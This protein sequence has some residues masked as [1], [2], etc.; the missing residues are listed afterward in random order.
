MV[1][2][3]GKCPFGCFI[4][5]VCMSILLYA[6]DILLIAPSVTSLQKLLHIFDHEISCIDMSINVKKSNCLTIGQACNHEC[7]KISKLHGRDRKRSDNIRY[8]GFYNKVS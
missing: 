1:N 4:K 5:N 6:D 2:K 3:V 7:R 8:L